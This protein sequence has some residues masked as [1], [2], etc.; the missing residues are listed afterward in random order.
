MFRRLQPVTALT[1]ANQL[2]NSGCNAQKY[3][4]A[5]V[6]LPYI[7][8]VAER[9][10]HLTAVLAPMEIAVRGYCGDADT[11]APLS[12]KCACPVPQV[13]VTQSL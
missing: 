1:K 8:V 13:L 5:L 11:V 7:S 3:R 4:R 9:T 2:A 6:V 12:H 10:A